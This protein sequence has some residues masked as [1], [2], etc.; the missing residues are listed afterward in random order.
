MLD[1][2]EPRL[3]LERKGRDALG[4]RR[5]LEEVARDDELL[6]AEVGE[7]ASVSGEK[8]GE[9]NLDS[10]ERNARALLQS[11]S[12]RSQLVKEDPIDHRDCST[13][14]KMSMSRHGRGWRRD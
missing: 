1:G 9:T 14:S 12:D 11:L 8:E 7:R 2:V 10:S 4:N 6:P 5:K 13:R 3:G